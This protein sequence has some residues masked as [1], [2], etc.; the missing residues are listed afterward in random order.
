[1]KKV[2]A[3]LLAGSLL[4]AHGASAERAIDGF[5]VVADVAVVRPI[6]FV[7]TVAGSALF[8]GLLPFT[9]LASIPS[10]HKGIEL[11]ADA[12]VVKPAKFTFAR[13]AGDFG[14]NKK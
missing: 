3:A 6:G 11:A 12:L 7:G 8:V 10:P 13:P 5:D 14:W 2:P 9:A 4:F 1:M